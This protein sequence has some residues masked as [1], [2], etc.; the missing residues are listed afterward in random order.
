L[1]VVELLMMNRLARDVFY[2]TNSEKY[3]SVK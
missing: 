2:I 3:A 1:F